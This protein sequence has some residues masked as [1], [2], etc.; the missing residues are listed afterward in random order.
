MSK[1]APF[2]VLGAGETARKGILCYPSN[3]TG[4]WAAKIVQLTDAEAAKPG[5]KFDL[6]EIEGEYFT[7]Y[8]CTKDSLRQYIATLQEA[9]EMWEKGGKPDEAD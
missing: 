4:G 5:T 3:E 6:A 9:L 1:E 2:V 7:L 8:F